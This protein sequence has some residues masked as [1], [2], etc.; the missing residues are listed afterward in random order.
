RDS[1]ILVLPDAG[2]PLIHL[3]AN[4]EN[5]VWVDEILREYRIKVQ[6]FI[7]QEQ[8]MQEITMSDDLE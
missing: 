7:D 8:G 2:E 6:D 4:S 5:R 1:W 3:C